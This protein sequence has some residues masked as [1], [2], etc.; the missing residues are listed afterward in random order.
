VKAAFMSVDHKCKILEQAEKLFMRYGVRS[1]TMDDVARDMTISKKTLYQHFTN[2]DDLVNE[3]ACTHFD[4]EKQEFAE[5]A[6]QSANAVDELFRLAV[7]MRDN[8]ANMN[9]SLLYDLQKYHG[10]AWD[11]YLDFKFNFIKGEIKRNIARGMAEGLYRPDLNP[12]VLAHF[13]VEQVQMVLDGRTFN[14]AQFDL[15]QVQ[16]VLFDHFARGLLSEKG[17]ALYQT[18]QLELLKNQ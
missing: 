3:V 1:V 2:K 15:W 14:P 16:M 9:P 11:C 8:I 5:I 18:Y 12:E 10:K 7:C 6:E 4:R 17:H 13:R